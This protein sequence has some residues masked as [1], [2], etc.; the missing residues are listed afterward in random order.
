MGT[1]SGAI[2]LALK[3]ARPRARITALDASGDALAIAREN[4]QR[5]QLDI[6]W[7]LSDWWRALGGQ[8][9]DLIVSNPPYIAGGDPHLVALRHEP[10]LA[11]TPGGDGLDSLRQIVG[12]APHHLN[13]GAWLLLEHGYD[14]AAAVGEMLRE[15]HFHSVTTRHDLAD[16]PRCTGGRCG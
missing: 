6:Q 4:G 1:G 11:L 8:R 12:G 3:H 9:F 16:Q 7:L 15:Q 5:L 13:P 14:Q 2:A 10:T